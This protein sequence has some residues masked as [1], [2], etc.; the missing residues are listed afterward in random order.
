MQAFREIDALAEIR[1]HVIP[2]ILGS[3]FPLAP[4]HA[5][6]LGLTLCSTRT[7][8]DGVIELGYALEPLPNAREG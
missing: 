4:D 2:L 8:P 6:P 7:F 1:L 5:A 3:G